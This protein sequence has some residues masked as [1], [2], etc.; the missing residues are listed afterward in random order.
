MLNLT[1][2]PETQAKGATGW[3][4]PTAIDIWIKPAAMFG[5][6]TD[7]FVIEVKS[8]AAGFPPIYLD[9]T[10]GDLERLQAE[11]VL[12]LAERW[13]VGRPGTMPRVQELM[14]H[15]VETI[16]PPTELTMQ[17]ILSMRAL[18]EAKARYRQDDRC[19]L[20][21]KLLGSLP[22][23]PCEQCRKGDERHA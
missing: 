1:P 17:Q 4:Q 8:A 3:F 21:G 22:V 23:Q 19:R 2:N 10:R 9:L 18:E 20:C 16:P 11:I 6:D 5:T 14:R 15:L 7:I 13:E 12:K